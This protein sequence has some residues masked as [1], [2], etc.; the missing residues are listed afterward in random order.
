MAPPHV[1]TFQACSIFRQAGSDAVRFDFGQG[2]QK[3]AREND[4][5]G[6][7]DYGRLL[8]E[9]SPSRRS[10]L[11]LPAGWRRFANRYQRNDTPIPDLQYRRP[12]RSAFVRLSGDGLASSA[13]RS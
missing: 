9:A 3:M 4:R 8:E 13:S 5:R 11:Q 7:A 12:A 6:R 10:W 1:V 2:W